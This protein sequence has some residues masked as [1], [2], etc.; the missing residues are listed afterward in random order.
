MRQNGFYE[1]DPIIYPRRLFVVLGRKETA[2]KA[3]DGLG[4]KPFDFPA[5]YNAVT[6]DNAIRKDTRHYGVL[7]YFRTKAEITAEVVAHEA[8]HVVDAI[9][10][11]TGLEHGGETSAYLIGWIVKCLNEARK[12]IG[13]FIE[14]KEGDR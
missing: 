14:L 13:N 5:E 12:D 10:E 8:S 9:E 7:V 6:F 2:L 4:D 3:F 1:Y 11:A